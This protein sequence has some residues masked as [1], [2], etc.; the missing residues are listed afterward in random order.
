M[1][2]FKTID[3]WCSIALLITFLVY[4]LI[5]LDYTFVYGYFVIGAWQCCSMIVHI[6]NH[7]FTTAIGARKNYHMAVMIILVL[8]LLGSV[9]GPLLYAV[10]F[11][12]L[13]AAPLMALYYT[14]LCYLELYVKMQ[15][16]LAQLK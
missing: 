6:W 11:C 4:S 10:M 3:Y 8:T 2:T 14:R 5:R 9:Y 1:K 13:F 15:R 12:M 16:P 7:W